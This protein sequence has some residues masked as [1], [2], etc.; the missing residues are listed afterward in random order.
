MPVH[1]PVSEAATSDRHAEWHGLVPTYAE[2]R[3]YTAAPVVSIEAIQS[4]HDFLETATEYYQMAI[5]ESHDWT[6][7]LEKKFDRL[8]AKVALDSASEQE[9]ATFDR[10]QMERFKNYLAPDGIELI[11]QRKAERL[12]DELLALAG[13][14]V[15]VVRRT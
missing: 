11:R 2:V 4:P 10:L 13:Q 7:I 3:S 12:L 15:K 8:A 1:A 5:P 9:I 14:Y 6:P